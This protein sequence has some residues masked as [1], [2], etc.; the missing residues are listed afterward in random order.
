MK[1][2]LRAALVDV[3]EGCGGPNAI[4]AMTGLPMARCEEIYDLYLLAALDAL[5]DENNAESGG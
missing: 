2:K 3:L 1:E 5:P 4:H